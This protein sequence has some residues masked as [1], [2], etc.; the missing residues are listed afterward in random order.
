VCAGCGA[1]VP[2]TARPRI[3]A[4]GRIELTCEPCAS[5]IR[6]VFVA[7]EPVEDVTL[8]RP[9]RKGRHA[10]LGAGAVALGIVAVA[11]TNGGAASHQ[12][13]AATSSLRPAGWDQVTLPADEEEA[14]EAADWTPAVAPVLASSEAP[15]VHP[16]LPQIPELDGEPLDEWLPALKDWT[17]PVPGSPDIVP[18]KGSRI[19]GAHR[20][21]T[22]NGCGGGHCGVD[23]EGERG[24][25]VVAVAWGTVVKIQRSD[26]ARGGRYVRIEHP[27]YVYTSYFHLD[28]IAPGLE[29]G[30]EVDPGQPIG[31]LG[32]SGIHISM[33]H[34]HFAIEIPD[35]NGAGGLRH[36]D[37]VPF[38]AR[39]HVL[40]RRA[41]PELAPSEGPIDA[42]P[43]AGP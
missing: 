38:L 42:D 14:L 35:E 1:N 7:V 5:G 25:P 23:L 8:V 31:T 40:G 36:I 19:F 12:A 16:A 21:G 24:Q 3:F 6:P 10:L 41:V 33:P 30:Q 32:R 29:I 11:L 26:G 39:A 4:D 17:H 28:R 15:A 13:A 2:L 27:D 18:I 37:P 20:D 9:R 22:R 34:L 43:N